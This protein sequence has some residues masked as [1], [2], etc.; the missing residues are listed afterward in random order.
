MSNY[1]LCC[2]LSVW[3]ALVKEIVIMIV[4]IYDQ[5]S[6]SA[7]SMNTPSWL[8]SPENITVNENKRKN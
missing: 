3:N 8:Y 1:L 2:Y 4:L 5:A 7:F 6:I